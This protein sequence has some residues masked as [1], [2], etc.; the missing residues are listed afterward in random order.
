MVETVL[1]ARKY[2]V[3]KWM[4]DALEG[5][6]IQKPPFIVQSLRDPIELDW[7]TIA[8]LFSIRDRSISYPASLQRPKKRCEWC[9]RRSPKSYR[10]KRPCTCRNQPLELTSDYD[11]DEA[12]EAN[13]SVIGWEKIFENVDSNTARTLIEKEFANETMYW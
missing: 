7:E 13:N 8:N 1:T 3:K 12:L 4:L 10:Y 2:H 5:L 9:T 11:E 6:V